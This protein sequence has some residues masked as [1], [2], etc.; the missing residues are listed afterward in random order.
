[1]DNDTGLLRVLSLILRDAGHDV[2]AVESGWAALSAITAFRPDLFIG[3]LYTDQTHGV[4]LLDELHRRRPGLPVLIVS[5]SCTV[6]GAAAAIRSGAFGLLT[7]PVDPTE[8]LEHVNEALLLYGS[9]DHKPDWRVDIVTRSP[10]ME[11]LLRQANM[12]A[13]AD[14]SVLITGPSGVGKELLARAI[15]NASLRRDRDF[16]ALNSGA[17]P[18]HLL[19]SE[20]FGH[21][22]GA[23]TGAM[24]SHKGLYHAADRGTLF[25]DEIG[26]MPLA[27]QV[28]LLRVL[29]EGLVRPVGSTQTI[30]VEVRVISATHRDLETAI[31]EGTFREDLFYRLNVV[32]LSVP[33]L[34]ERR[35]DIPLLVGHFLK[36]LAGCN[37]EPPKVYTSAAMERLV[38]ADWHGNVRQLSNVVKQNVALSPTPVIGVRLVERA[39]GGNAEMMRPYAEARAEFT[40]SYLTQVLQITRGNVSQAARLAEH[41]RADLYKLLARHNIDPALFKVC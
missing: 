16:V 35:E 27:L 15:H 39:L 23:F 31:A 32:K 37:G 38:T 33:P 6:S 14:A 17:I 2:K 9:A 7:K 12:V 25:L 28:K 40:H 18:E 24:H 41:N 3:D 30:P 4:D 19:E 26:D 36:E 5:G 10:A 29:E 13:D 11:D 8:L 22:Q 20:L 1:V 21:K 34:N